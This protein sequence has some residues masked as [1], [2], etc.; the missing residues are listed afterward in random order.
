[1]APLAELEDFFRPDSVGCSSNY[2]P[3]D[4]MTIRET[5]GTYRGAPCAIIE[6]R[7]KAKAVNVSCSTVTGP[8]RVYVYLAPGTRRVIARVKDEWD[9]QE[10]GVLL[11]GIREY[12]YNVTLS[13]SLFI[14]TPPPGSTM[15]A[16][17]A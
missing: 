2:G 15:R 12:E 7:F 10:R 9:M 11:R 13:D 6:M 1:L 8:C 3:M 5:T 4:L 17:G 14:F 16:P